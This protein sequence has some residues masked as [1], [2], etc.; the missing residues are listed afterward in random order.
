M[1]FLSPRDPQPH[2]ADR[3]TYGEVLRLTEGHGTDQIYEYL[4]GLHQEIHF[5]RQTI[6]NRGEGSPTRIIGHLFD[7]A[8]A[9]G[10][11]KF[12]ARHA[13]TF[14]REHVAHLQAEVN[15]ARDSL[16]RQP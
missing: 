8:E 14:L 12:S 7:W 9:L 15:T 16:P 4:Q 3:M 1:S 13:L 2:D 11:S 5:L 6:S 10:H